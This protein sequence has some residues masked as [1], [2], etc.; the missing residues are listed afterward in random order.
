MANITE[1]NR[2]LLDSLKKTAE[3]CRENES[4]TSSAEITAG[5]TEEIDLDSDTNDSYAEKKDKLIQL[6]NDR[7][8]L[9]EE[10]KKS[11]PEYK[12]KGEEAKKLQEEIKNDI[13]KEIESCEKSIQDLSN[14]SKNAMIEQII[15]A[16][17]DEI[18]YLNSLLNFKFSGFYGGRQSYEDATD[19]QKQIVDIINNPDIPKDTRAN[20]CQAYVND[21][22]QAAGIIDGRY[23]CATEA[24][25]G[26]GE[27]LSSDLENIPVGACLFSD[28]SNPTVSCGDHDAGHVAIYIGDGKVV[29]NVG[30]IQTI[31]VDDWI[32]QWSVGGR[33]VTWGWINGKDLSV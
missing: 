21:V 32:S 18:D 10:G 2:G 22:F 6:I 14:G 19:A 3:R 20:Y 23:D 7:K 13:Q 29:H 30:G 17:Q 8:K 26:T 16:N 33:K 4:T 9:E 25:W 5:S 1:G 11:S 24:C 15:A 27:T 12:E 28:R 31:S